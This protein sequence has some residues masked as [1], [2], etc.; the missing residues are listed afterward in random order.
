[1]INDLCIVIGV[2][3]ITSWPSPRTP[4]SPLSTAEETNFEQEMLECLPLMKT[5]SSFFF[6][7]KITDVRFSLWI[8]ICA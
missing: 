4:M 8:S 6:F 3:I 1:M 2:I 7:D 5:C